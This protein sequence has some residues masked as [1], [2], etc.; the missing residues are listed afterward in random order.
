M[1]LKVVLSPTFLQARNHF[2]FSCVARRLKISKIIYFVYTHQYRIRLNCDEIFFTFTIGP[3]NCFKTQNVCQS[4]NEHMHGNIPCQERVIPSRSSQKPQKASRDKPRKLFRSQKNVLPRYMSPPVLQFWAVVEHVLHRSLLVSSHSSYSNPHEGVRIALPFRQKAQC[5][6]SASQNQERNFSFLHP[7]AALR[8][9][10]S[11][12]LT[13][14]PTLHSPL[15]ST[16]IHQKS[17]PKKDQ[18]PTQN[19]FS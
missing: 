12:S 11:Y 3:G 1:V 7:V 15:P 19:P 4:L 18:Q 2:I 9:E 5:Q 14:I 16:L 10:R 17:L 13:R 6:P 8:L